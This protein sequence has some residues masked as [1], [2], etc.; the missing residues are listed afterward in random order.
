[1]CTTKPLCCRAEISTTL[2]INYTSMKKKTEKKI[3][4][5]CKLKSFYDNQ[6]IIL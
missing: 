3:T 1:M 6:E 5:E 2:Q 4:A